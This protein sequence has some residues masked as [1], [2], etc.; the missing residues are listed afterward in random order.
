MWASD[1]AGVIW[2]WCDF[3]YLWKA[4]EEMFRT[5]LIVHLSDYFMLALD[6]IY[7]VCIY[8][9][10]IAASKG[11]NFSKIYLWQ[12]FSNSINLMSSNM[13]AHINFIHLR[14]ITSGKKHT[15]KNASWGF[16]FSWFD[17]WSGWIIPCSGPPL[18]YTYSSN[19]LAMP[20]IGIFSFPNISKNGC[21][22][23][24]STVCKQ[25]YLG[26]WSCL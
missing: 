23:Q 20:N 18:L 24:T 16:S 13:H 2:K 14:E 6:V 22:K 11:R 19:G 4:L 17:Q 9:L 12:R 10:T 3:F 21:L 7:E 1:G 5:P 25:L 15:Q 8:L 26:S